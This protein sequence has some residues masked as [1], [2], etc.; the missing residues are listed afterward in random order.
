MI[1]AETG[2][3]SAK[4][5]PAIDLKRFPAAE[6]EVLKG[7]LPYFAAGKSSGF[8]FNVKERNRKH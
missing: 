4:E 2:A 3:V 5:N 6:Y 7:K 1:G 8:L